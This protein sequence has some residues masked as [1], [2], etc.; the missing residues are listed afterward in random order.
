MPE[1]LELFERSIH[2]SIGIVRL[3]YAIDT[4][5]ESVEIQKL[6]ERISGTKAKRQPH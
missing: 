6:F 2:D 3:D 4:P 1:I 5:Y